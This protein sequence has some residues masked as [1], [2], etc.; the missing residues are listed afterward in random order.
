MKIICNES[1]LEKRKILLLGGSAQQLVAIRAA[2]AMGYFTV[3]CDYLPDNPGQYEADVY[4]NVSTTDVE[5]VYDVALKEGVSGI[6]AYASDPAALPAA[7]VAERLG[8]PTNPSESVAI[9][10]VKHKF[11]E[12]L[13]THQFACPQ[14]YSFHP[15]QSIEEIRQA[16]VHFTFPLV[17]KPTD[18]SGSKGVSIMENWEGLDKAILYADSY[19][20]NKI[21]IIEEFIMRGFP[22]V[23]G[24]DVFVWNG[25]IVLYGDMTCLRDDGG[26]SLVPIGKR[27]PGG[28]NSLQIKR[29]HAELQRLV[30][31]LGIRFGE[32][33]IE[34]LLDK[35]DEVH[36]LELGPRAG[37]NMIPLQLSDAFGVDLVKANVAA[38]MGVS[39]NLT[40]Q[41]KDGCFMTFVLHSHT[42]GCFSHV[43]Y[44]DEIAPCV[45]R[46]V[47][48]KQKG[49]K[50]EVFD[51]A[52]KAI[53]IVFLHIDTEERMNDFCRRIDDLIKVILQ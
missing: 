49:D 29:V 42:D 30:T 23:I 20:R 12:F 5:A 33:N 40:I 16:V 38:A 36:F 31:M 48:Y 27:K 4:Y 47:L 15:G 32:L 11:R 13:Q 24:G 10:G 7:I 53:G 45:Y 51:G 34:I 14:T 52:G 18:S 19:S 1:Y 50:V 46:E 17:V 22:D 9:L 44:A 39:P 26:R 43:E 37:G 25:K 2:K 3:L 41:P 8:L 6:L 35:E 21:L 28:L